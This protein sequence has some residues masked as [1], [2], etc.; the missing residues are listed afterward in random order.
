MKLQS[1]PHFGAN[2]I[3]GYG[4]GYG[5]GSGSGYGDG[6]GSGYG[7]G[8]GSGYGYGDGYGDGDGSG[9]GSGYGDKDE[10]FFALLTPYQGDGTVAFWRSTMDGRP[11]NGG[12]GLA[13]SVGVI[14]F[15]SGTLNLCGKTA[16][17][18][19]LKPSVWKGERW[20]IV[21]LS[22]PVIGDDSKLGSQRREILKDLGKCPF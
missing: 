18:A 5:D 7:Y 11:A 3:T 22:S 6:S 13:R 17:H 15:T 16:L 4:A 21:R 9:D 19:T 14:D 8:D 20:W 10:Y 12:T 1:D 2:A